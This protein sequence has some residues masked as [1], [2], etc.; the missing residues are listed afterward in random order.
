MLNIDNALLLIIDVQEKLLPVIFE[1]EKLISNIQ[2][3]IKGCTLMGVPVIITE[4]N[5]SG[6]GTTVKEL[7]DSV[8][9]VRPVTKFGFSCCSEP[10]FNEELSAAARRQ[11]LICGI[12]SHICVYQTSMDLLSSGN[13]V[14][15]VTDCVSSR[16]PE[17]KELSMRRLVSEVVK[18][19]GMEMA[20]F[21][22]LR[23]SKSHHFKTISAL[24]K[25]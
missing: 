11:I 5:P 25:N 14:H 3:L 19:T 7:Q 12:E 9:S 21:E 8:P 18:L 20:L 10:G 17:N 1:K 16:T 23:S 15:I 2:K 24:I 13:E 22:L 4:Q 6:L